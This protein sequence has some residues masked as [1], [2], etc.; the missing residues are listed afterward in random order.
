MPNLLANALN[1]SALVEAGYPV[2]IQDTRG[3]YRSGGEVTPMLDEPSDGADTVAGLAQQSWC[4]GSI[5]T[6]GASYLGFVQWTVTTTDYY[7][8]PWYSD[9][10]ALSL[11]MSLWWS[12]VF[13][14]QARAPP[15]NYRPPAPGRPGV[16]EP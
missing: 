6:Y 5:G 13:G 8:S 15:E 9:G 12:T 3:T 7:T 4:N 1:T 11:H 10:G 14:S 2:A 16:P